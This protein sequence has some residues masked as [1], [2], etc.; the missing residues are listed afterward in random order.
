MN[1]FTDQQIKEAGRAVQSVAGD[2]AYL[3][4]NGCDVKKFKKEIDLIVEHIR[5]AAK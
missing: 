5:K 4:S 1:G 3:Y 2:R